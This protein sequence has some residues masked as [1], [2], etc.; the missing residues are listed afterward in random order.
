MYF[1]I[2]T[3]Q[4]NHLISLIS[5]PSLNF[6]NIIHLYLNV[7]VTLT[8]GNLAIPS[9]ILNIA[10]I[11]LAKSLLTLSAPIILVSIFPAEL[12]GLG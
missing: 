5:I 12:P 1:F 11:N 4:T 2:K 8:L 3:P 10:F 6:E 9:P 7:H